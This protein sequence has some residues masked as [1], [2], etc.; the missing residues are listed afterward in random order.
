M[1]RKSVTIDLPFFRASSTSEIKQ[2]ARSTAKRFRRTLKCV[3]AATWYYTVSRA[4][5]LTNSRSNPLPRQLRKTIGSH[6]PTSIRSHFPTFRIITIRDFLK[7][8]R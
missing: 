2:T 4:I 5:R 7:T 8:F 3:F 1:S 6:K